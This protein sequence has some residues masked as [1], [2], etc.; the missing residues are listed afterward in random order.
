MDVVTG[1]GK[2][3]IEHDIRLLT[4]SNKVDPVV[5]A[6][7]RLPFR[8]EE[9]AF[10]KLDDM[11][12]DGIITPVQKPTEWVSRIMVVGKPDGDVRICLD[13]SELN[14][15]I[16]RH[17]FAVPTFEK[18]FSKLSNARYF[19]SLDAASGFNKI[20]LTIASSYLCTMATPK[21][22]YRFLRLPFGQKSAPEVYLQ[23]MSDLFGDIPGVRIY[24]DDFLVTGETMEELLFNLRRTCSYVVAYTT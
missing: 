24:F 9:R 20:P 7:S 17:H 1:L 8:L 12:A 10:K 11:V 5:C 3:P 14:K 15:T 6:A 18:L 22:E 19:C 23:A 21:G 16:Q 13:P 4:G 2:L